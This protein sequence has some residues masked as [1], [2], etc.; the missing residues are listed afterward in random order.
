MS[1]KTELDSAEQHLKEALS[2]IRR[3]NKN[4]HTCNSQ[5]HPELFDIQ[6]CLDHITDIW[7]IYNHMNG[8]NR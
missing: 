6:E 2:L 5:T 1:L 3:M 8:G 7:T 4:G